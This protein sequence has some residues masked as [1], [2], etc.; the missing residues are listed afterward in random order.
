MINEVCVKQSLKNEACKSLRHVNMSL[1]AKRNLQTLYIA[2]TSNSFNFAQYE[3]MLSIY[4]VKYC[5]NNNALRLQIMFDY[6]Q[7]LK[8][9]IN[10]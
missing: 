2:T 6:K 1:Q 5:G 7:Y 9:K 8:L 4:I 10:L 3:C